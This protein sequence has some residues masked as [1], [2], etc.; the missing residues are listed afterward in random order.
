MRS[1]TGSPRSN[2]LHRL[3]GGWSDEQARE[4][5]RILAPFGEID[6]DCSADR[7]VRAA[8]RQLGESDS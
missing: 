6:V 1:A 3:A 2:G 5:E 4:F 8:A 7:F